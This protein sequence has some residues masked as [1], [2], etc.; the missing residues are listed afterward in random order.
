MFNFFKKNKPKPTMQHEFAEKDHLSTEEIAQFEQKINQLQQQINTTDDVLILAELCEK[1]GIL[2]YQLD[3]VD[4]S[5]EYLERSLQYKK[6]IG[7]GYKTLMSLYNHKRAD[8]AKNGT[9]ADIDYWMNK[10]DAM[11]NIA[12]EVTIQRH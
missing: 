1:N 9:I 10:I 2:Y 4:E 8:A 5:I 11:R 3:R 7:D 6:S 12:K